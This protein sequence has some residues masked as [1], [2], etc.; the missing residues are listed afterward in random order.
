V[1][2]SAVTSKTDLPSYKSGWDAASEYY[3]DF[4]YETGLMEAYASS[5]SRLVWFVIGAIAGAILALLT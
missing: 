1:D 5:P 2:S 3:R 4:S